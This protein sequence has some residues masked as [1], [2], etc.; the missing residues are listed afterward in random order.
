MV[1]RRKEERENAMDFGAQR[2]KLVHDSSFLV[3]EGVHRG[4]F[5]LIHESCRDAGGCP[6]YQKVAQHVVETVATYGTWS[7]R[8]VSS[9]WQMRRSQGYQHHA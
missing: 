4:A 9:P 7:D 6:I 2:D 3:T 5:L 1:A 8:W